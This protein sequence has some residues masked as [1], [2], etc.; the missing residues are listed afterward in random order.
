MRDEKKAA[1]AAVAGPSDIQDLLAIA[2]FLG[3]AKDRLG[4]PDAAANDEMRA[5]RE[6]IRA[7]AVRHGVAGGH[8]TY[9]DQCAA[10]LTAI[11]IKP[12]DAQ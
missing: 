12:G 7:A 9:I 4:R 5:A 1:P 10:V 11:A 3:G 6:A 2:A 8:H